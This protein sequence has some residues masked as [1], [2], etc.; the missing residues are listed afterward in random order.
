M[1]SKNFLG[2]VR[3]LDDAELK[4]RGRTLHEE[5]MKLRFRG[6]SGQLTQSHRIA[7]VRVSL[8]RIETVLSER[9]AKAG[10]NAKTSA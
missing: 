1:K 2:E 9:R 7:E 10:K 6:A 4:A 8:A 5:M 3:G